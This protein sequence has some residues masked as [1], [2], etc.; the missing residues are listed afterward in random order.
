VKSVVDFSQ[1]SDNVLVTI[2][3]KLDFD[4][5]FQFSGV[6]KEWRRVQKNYWRSFMVSQSP[7]LVQTTSYAKK[8]CSSYSI[9]KK[10]G[11]HAKMRYFLVL[12]YL[13]SCGGYLIMKGANKLQ[14]MIPFIRK[15]MVI[16]TSAIK[17]YF[18]CYSS[19][20]LLTF[21][22]GS[23]E[24]VIEAYCIISSSLHVY[25]TRYSSV[26][27]YSKSGNPLIVLDFVVL[28]NTVHVLT[29]KVEIGV[30]SLNSTGLKFLELKNSPSGPSFLPMLHS[31][32]VKLLV[33]SFNHN[34]LLDVYR[35][36]FSTMSF[37]KLETLGDLALFFS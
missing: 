13:S 18:F 37:V 17:D 21:V 5:L 22:K 15:Q 9:P 19:R 29:D 16:D 20:V 25:Q 3:L 26:V 7:L 27:T 32:D 30:L 14:L 11:Y 6:G 4:D 31:C 33:V 34:K 28:N 23:D 35:I 36:D 1:L 10:R 24:F 12:S 8:F 2:S